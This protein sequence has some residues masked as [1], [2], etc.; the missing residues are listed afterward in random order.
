MIER[1]KDYFLMQGIPYW[2]DAVGRYLMLLMY[3]EP[4]ITN[5]V[6]CKKQEMGQSSLVICLPMEHQ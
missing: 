3:I 1:H 5:T 2:A 6:M 4:F